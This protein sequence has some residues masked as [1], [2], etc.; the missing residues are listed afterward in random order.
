VK[1]GLVV[2]LPFV[3]SSSVVLL[4][5]NNIISIKMSDMIIHYLYLIFPL[6]SLKALEPK[7]MT[8]KFKCLLTTAKKTQHVSITKIR[9]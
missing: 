3:L 6:P 8:V 7:V 5:K 1:E 4:F 2:C 9:F